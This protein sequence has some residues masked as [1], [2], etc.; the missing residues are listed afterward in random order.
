VYNNTCKASLFDKAKIGKQK[1]KNKQNL[2][3]S[4]KQGEH[5]CK[6]IYARTV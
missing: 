3:L 2:V 5:D 6:N 1:V 4:A